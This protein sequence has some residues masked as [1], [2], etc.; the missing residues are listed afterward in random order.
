MTPTNTKL[1]QALRD[2]GQPE[3]AETAMT[4]RWHDYL[5]P[6]DLPAI[7]LVDQLRAKGTPEC[8]ALMRRVMLGE[9]D[10]PAEEWTDG[11][12]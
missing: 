8:A 4:G 1:A 2:A 5:S 6:L 10:A 7:D 9:F 12:A 11:P 3:M